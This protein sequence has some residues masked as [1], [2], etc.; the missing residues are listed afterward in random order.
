MSIRPQTSIISD[1]GIKT[2]PEHTEDNA[3]A[4]TVLTGR[5]RPARRG[6]RSCRRWGAWGRWRAPRS[7]FLPITRCWWGLWTWLG[8]RRI[9]SRYEWLGTRWRRPPLPTRWFR[10][11]KKREDETSLNT[12]TCRT[13]LSFS[14]LCNNEQ[15]ALV[16]EQGLWKYHEGWMNKTN[17]PRS[18]HHYMYLC[19][20]WC[21]CRW[22]RWATGRRRWCWKQNMNTNIRVYQSELD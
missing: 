19:R 15:T 1:Q 21:S 9:I 3:T 20:L 16:H 12:I 22:W 14:A 5:C 11:K 2:T 4:F 7:S 13:E 10:L 17:N 18:I 8:G 6:G